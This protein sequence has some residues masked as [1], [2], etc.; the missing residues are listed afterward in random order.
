MGKFLKKRPW[1]YAPGGG[2]H[3]DPRYFENVQ[4]FS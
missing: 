3:V 4:F 2:G 1:P